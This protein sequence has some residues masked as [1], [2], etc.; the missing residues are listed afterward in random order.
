MLGRVILALNSIGIDGQ[1]QC[2]TDMGLIH[3]AA[4]DLHLGKQSWGCFTRLEDLIVIIEP[5]HIG[6]VC[7]VDIQFQAIICR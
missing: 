5:L 4:Y 7:S 2:G 6:P 3:L 1:A